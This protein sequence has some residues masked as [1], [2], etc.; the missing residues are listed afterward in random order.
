M[1]N[2]YRMTSN[3]Q[4]IAQL[5]AP[6]VNTQVNLPPFHEIYPDREAPVLVARDDARRIETMRWGWPPS[7][8]VKRPVTNIRN[9][10]S[11]M[12][13][14]ALGDPARRC[15]VPVTAFSEWS[16]AADPVTGR[17]RK[18]WFA[19]KEQPLF[20]FAGLWRVAED[21]ARFAF[22]TCEPNKLVGRIHPK[23]MPVII[24]SAQAADRWL[25]AD[26]VGAAAM[27]RAYSDAAMIEL[28]FP[29][30]PPV[31]ASLF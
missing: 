16:H 30:E 22:L 15:L 9:L 17:K 27:Q 31:Q 26:G 2:L 11:P 3:V 5:F 1:C 19:L 21:G 8:D 24:G 25:S 10:G 29:E 4:A 12:W 28:D 18:H 23:A 6:V 14:T 7:G 13:R 20:A